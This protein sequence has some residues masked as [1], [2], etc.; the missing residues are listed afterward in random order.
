MKIRPLSSPQRKS[1]IISL[2]LLIGFCGLGAYAIEGKRD[3]HESFVGS[4]V[5]SDIALARTAGPK[6]RRSLYLPPKPAL[7]FNNDSGSQFYR[8]LIESIKTARGN[9]RFS[10]YKGC[11]KTSVNGYEI[12]WQALSNNQ[13]AYLQFKYENGSLNSATLRFS[14]AIK[15]KIPDNSVWNEIETIE[16]KKNGEVVSPAVI[17][18]N[19]DV[20][21]HFSIAGSKPEFLFNG[22]LFFNITEAQPYNG[23]GYNNQPCD[24]I[25][26]TVNSVFREVIFEPDTAS[27]IEALY[28]ELY[29]DHLIS[30]SQAQAAHPG[31]TSN[32]I[33]TDVGSKFEFTR[34]SYNTKS[35]KLAASLRKFFLAVKKG[36]FDSGGFKLTFAAGSVLDLSNANLDYNE[37]TKKGSVDMSGGE[38]HAS[39][40]KESSLLLSGNA[41]KTTSLDFDSGD[42][43][44]KA[45]S[46][47]FD[48]ET[49][50]K[51]EV[52][53]DSEI[54]VDVKTGEL[55]FGQTGRINLSG[56]KLSISRLRGS[57][58]TGKSPK[59]QGDIT[60]FSLNIFDGAVQLN[61]SDIITL[62]EGQI[63][64]NKLKLRNTDCPDVLNCSN[65]HPI[66]PAVTGP[67]DFINLKG[68]SQSEITLLS[69]LKFRSAEPIQ[70]LAT[71][72]NPLTIVA[73]KPYPVGRVEIGAAYQRLSFDK[74]PN[75]ALINGRIK[76][77]LVNE[78]VPNSSNLLFRAENIYFDGDIDRAELAFGPF[79][80]IQTKGDNIGEK[81]IVVNLNGVWQVGKPPEF[82]GTVDNIEAQ[83]VSGS[84]TPTAGSQLRLTGGSLKSKNLVIDSKSSR[85]ITGTIDELK[86]AV[87]MGSSFAIPNGFK[88]RTLDSPDALVATSPLIIPGNGPNITGKFMIKLLFD[89]LGSESYQLREGTLVLPLEVKADN[90]I[91]G[92]NCR[93]DGRM[94]V[95]SSDV[96]TMGF[97]VAFR[98]GMLNVS[99]ANPATLNGNLSLNSLADFTYAFQTPS[100]NGI[101]DHDDFRIFKINLRLKVP[102]FNIVD[103]PVSLIG[104]SITFDKEFT[105]NGSLE[106]PKGR[107]EHPNSS[108]D[109]EGNGGGPNWGRDKQEV[110]TDKVPL[111]RVHLYVFDGTVPL[112]F[113]FK[114]GQSGDKLAITLKHISLLGDLPEIK[115]DGGTFISDF[116]GPIIG[117]LT[118]VVTG[119]PTLGIIIGFKVNEFIKDKI[120][121]AKAQILI[122]AAE[123]IE[124]FQYTWEIKTGP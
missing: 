104:R 51:I 21:Q 45:P 1:K 42:V 68:E 53:T 35:R 96:G 83:I 95:T 47:S 40:G 120:S 94:F 3:R 58:Q 75:L 2:I 92:E 111:G 49:G 119:S 30:F 26:A 87:G 25:P 76:A 10:M 52:G 65:P 54:N 85:V 55:G 105:I 109:E 23:T 118:T 24:P 73:D 9:L 16:Y 113:T 124:C 37:V 43:T 99:G 61:D 74:G 101:P 69:G 59:I 79:G 116:L 57:W 67:F 71:Q 27:G 98:N 33:T 11:W 20:E 46:L 110:W 17:A 39:I 106:I 86:V 114:V 38:I 77:T 81:D 80:K 70:L 4:L 117:A 56:G 62:R 6:L 89:T 78:A 48:D 91:T 123:R 12:L 31:I 18:D 36:S 63:R 64:S 93:F 122:R 108:V 22:Q 121:F 28:V 102:A 84:L 107:G 112:Q 7:D 19:F 88:A 97:E 90:S 60:S 44:I 32:N 103:I 29:Q 41:A 115:E 5:S 72:T 66:H 13:K 15:I 14:P 82:K 50:A 100:V 8:T 34:I